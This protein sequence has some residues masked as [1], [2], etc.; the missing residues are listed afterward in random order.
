MDRA[1]LIGLLLGGLALF[2]GHLMEGG[3]SSTIFQLTALVIVFGGTAGAVCLSFSSAQLKKAL[4]SLPYIFREP[5][6]DRLEQVRRLVD[7]AYRA[8][9]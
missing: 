9:R 8:R 3:S 1:T 4:A 2:G 5:A 6:D 7:L